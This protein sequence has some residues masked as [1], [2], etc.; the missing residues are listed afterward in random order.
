[1]LSTER[2][3]PRNLEEIIAPDSIV[4]QVREWCQAWR[5]GRGHQEGPT[6]LRGGAWRREDVH[7]LRH[8]R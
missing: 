4:R 6:A 8:I 5:G 1:M 7:G 3:R 2:F